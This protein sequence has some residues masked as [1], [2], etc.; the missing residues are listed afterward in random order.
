M[1]SLTDVLVAF[2]WIL[3]GAGTH[4]LS[5]QPIPLCTSSNRW[6]ASLP[7]QILALSAACAQSKAELS[8]ALSFS[9]SRRHQSCPPFSK[10]KHVQLLELMLTGYKR[11]VHKQCR[12]GGSWECSPLCH[13]A[14]VPWGF[15]ICPPV[16]SRAQER[17]SWRKSVC[18]P[19]GGFRLDIW[20]SILKLRQDEEWSN[21]ENTYNTS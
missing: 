12:H 5:R 10:G 2:A 21:N 4:C 18:L 13:T 16:R 19:L 11:G 9:N 1:T 7:P 8:A 17:E 14:G 6:M 3:S 15:G 20:T